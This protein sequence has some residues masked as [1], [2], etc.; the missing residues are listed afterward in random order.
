VFENSS[1]GINTRKGAQLL[2]QNNVFINVSKPLYETDGGFAAAQG[3]DFGGK[4]NTAPVGTLTTVP[5]SYSLESVSS[6]RSNVVGVAGANL[7][8]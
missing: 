7:G 5:Y 3:N 8:F 4:S 2:V 1:D 6:V